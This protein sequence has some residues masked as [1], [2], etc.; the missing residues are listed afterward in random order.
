MINN[1]KLHN[2]QSHR[3]SYLEFDKGINVI[4][5]QSNQGKTAVLRALNWVVNNKP[6]G[7]AFKSHNSEKK[8]VCAVTLSINGHEITRKKND[9]INSYEIDSSVFSTL[10]NSIPV[11]VSSAIGMT[12]INIQTQFERHFLLMDSPGEVGRT[13]N[14]I[15]NLEIIDSLI[16]SINSKVLSINKE[17]EIK[18]EELNIIYQKL[19]KFKDLDF[20]ENS[21]NEIVELNSKLNRLKDE[22]F[23]LFHLR[24]ELNKVEFIISENETESLDLETDL[25][26]LRELWIQYNSA[27]EVKKAVTDDVNKVG[28]AEQQI[29]EFE[30]VVDLEQDRDALKNIID[31]F[32]EKVD[33]I[34]RLKDIV[35][36]F[37]SLSIKDR[38]VA[39]EN[40]EVEFN[41]FIKVNGCP[42][43]NRKG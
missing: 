4:M 37:K 39:V 41:E 31:I 21:V 19:D 33:D 24:N 9:S 12:G 5:G 18:K 7:L 22:V 34:K 3:D 17:Y 2:F 6:S 8:D 32:I 36:K 15:V 16:S 1:I 14:K 40:A 35:T 42:L 38:E 11:E 27:L 30:K 20:I 10:G 23:A 28:I 13:V 26:I 29:V 25:N 43:C